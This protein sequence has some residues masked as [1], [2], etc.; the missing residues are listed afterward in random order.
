MC[1][2]LVGRAQKYN[3]NKINTPESITLGDMNF[4]KTFIRL[5]GK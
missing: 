3:R 1:L 2:Q 4:N 5:Q